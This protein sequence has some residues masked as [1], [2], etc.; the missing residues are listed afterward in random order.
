MLS[1]ME[2]GLIRLATA[3]DKEDMIGFTRSFVQ[4]IRLGREAVNRE[5]LPW[6]GELDTG[7]SGIMCLGMGGSAAGGDFLSVLC[8]VS[9]AVPVRC[10]RGYDLPNWWTPDWLIIATSYSGNTEET[11]EA[12]RQAMAQDA[13]IVVISSGGELAGMCE[14]SST[15]HLISC[16]SGQPPRSAFG[17]IFSRQLSL[18]VEIGILQTEIT[19]DALMRLQLAVEDNDIITHPEGDVASLALNLMNNP[20]SI[21]GPNELM[22]AVNRFKNQLNENSAR[23]ARIGAVP[24]MNHNEAVAWGG[25]GEDQDPEAQD[26][27]II[28]LSWDEM[29]PRVSQRI[30]WFVSNCPTELAWK[31]HGVGDSLLEC[32]LH[33]CI[34]TDWLSI[35]LGLLHGKDPSAIEPIISLKEFLAQINQ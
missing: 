29:H 34:M 31:I 23:F 33:L 16:P 11:L 32:L 22:P 17:H 21:I 12:C 14:L 20:I 28:F 26:Q 6:L 9:G 13:T 30:D 35:A 3:L 10:H 5:L 2:E 7:W 24:E 8:D 27:A 19:E 1:R 18:L 25:V 4:D 15:M